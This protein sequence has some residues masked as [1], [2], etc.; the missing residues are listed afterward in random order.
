MKIGLMG[1]W[2]TDSGASIHSELVGRAWVKKGVDLTVFTF[3]RESFHGT[4]IIGDDEAYVRRCF[5]TSNA[6]PEVLNPVPFLVEDYDVL[7]VEDLGML[8]KD[9]LGKIFN[10]IKKKAITVNIIHDGKLTEDPSFYQ[11]NWDSLVCFDK[12]YEKFLREG[13]KNERIE[14]IPYPC[15]SWTP[16]DK[17]EAR[18]ALDLPLDKKIVFLFGPASEYA[19]PL[20]PALSSLTSKY[21]M[22][23]LLVSSSK[24]ALQKWN[25]FR[26]HPCLEIREESPDL[27]RLY[28]YLYSADL[29]LYN[30]PSLPT[31]PVSSTALQ[32]LGSGCPIVALS[33]NFVEELKDVVYI[34]ESEKEMLLCMES[35][36][37]QDESSKKIAE[38]QERYVRENSAD[39]VADKFLTLFSS[40]LE[41]KD[42]FNS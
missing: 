27:A 2:N 15:F 24:S 5:S 10:R 31:V 38:S 6:V 36:F 42:T 16:G 20:F 33:S 29:L 17:R 7:V 22:L 40:L 9:H 3:L 1:A 32:S 14:I 21:P 19:A 34:Y 41:K 18:K 13:Y 39:L 28:E 23:I 35:V 11:F 8:P 30:K 4:A 12:R 25:E 37:N 26:G